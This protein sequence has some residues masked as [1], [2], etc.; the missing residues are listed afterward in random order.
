MPQKTLS[1]LALTLFFVLNAG[2]AWAQPVTGRTPADPPPRKGRMV[3]VQE[4]FEPTFRIE[5]L[6]QKLTGRIGDEIAFKFTLEAA[7]RAA[8]VEVVP[9]G[10]RQEMTGLILHDESSLQAEAIRL[11]TPRNMRLQ[12]NQP[13]AIEGFVRIPRGEAK[14][15]SFGILVKDIGDAANLTPTNE[16]GKRKTQAGV[17]FIT[18]YVLRLDVSVENARGEGEREL[19]IESVRMTPFEG[20]PRLQAI[21]RNPTDTTF[22]FELKA[23]M[24]SSPSDRSMKPLHLVMPVRAS[25]ENDE[26]YVGRLLPKSRVRMEELLPEAIPGGSYEVEVEMFVRGHSVHRKSFKINVD[27]KDYPAQEVLI[28]QLGESLQVS[29]AQLE[30]S[31]LRGGNRRVS[32]LLKNTGSDTKTITLEALDAEGFEMSTVVVQPKEVTISP[33]GSRKVSVLLQFQK[34]PDSAAKYGKLFIGSRSDKKDFQETRELP[35]AVLFKKGP[36]A[37][38]TMSGFAVV[39]VDNY[40]AIHAKVTNNGNGH[41]PL[42]ARLTIIGENGRSEQ[43]LGGFGRWLMPGKTDRLEFRL[44]HP[45]TPDKYTFRC[46]LKV[47]DRIIVEEKHFEATDN[48]TAVGQTVATAAP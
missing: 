11:V 1:A 36:P 17:R 19:E 8:N 34:E 45:L 25:M 18:Q 9:M 23:K 32:L 29:P 15:H 47:D 33:G 21:V 28:A 39:S 4:T 2:V 3:N 31:Q 6:S 48:E 5:P 46:E 14:F 26:R 41:V 44:D 24:R 38:V 42:D 27:A 30:L 43:V 16:D 10:L 13:V 22:E 7:D 40:T 12:S 35:L 20:R 37:D